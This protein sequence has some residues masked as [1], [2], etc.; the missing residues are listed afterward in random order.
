[1]GGQHGGQG[2]GAG[3][4]HQGRGAQLQPAPVLGAHVAGSLLQVA[5]QALL[6]AGVHLSAQSCARAEAELACCVPGSA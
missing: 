3:V 5:D 4:C 6:G 1:M 2:D